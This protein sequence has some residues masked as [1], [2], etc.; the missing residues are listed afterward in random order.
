MPLVRYTRKW[1]FEFDTAF[2]EEV[3][4]CATTGPNGLFSKGVK[5]NQSGSAFWC[6]KFVPKFTTKTLPIC[7]INLAYLE[8]PGMGQ[9]F[10]TL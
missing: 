10:R 7:G 5:I 9:F 6:V 1:S 4:G 8:G 3:G 2:S